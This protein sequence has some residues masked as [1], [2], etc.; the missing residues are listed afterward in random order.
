MERATPSPLS[1]V[2]YRAKV[3]ALQTK[4]LAFDFRFRPQRLAKAASIPTDVIAEARSTLWREQDPREWANEQGKV[5][6]LRVAAKA[7]DGLAIPAGKVFSFWKH[8]GRTTRGKGYVFGRQI[9]E[10]CL[11][12]A[13]G[14]GICQLTNLLYEVALNA[15]CEIVERHPHSR[16]VPG[17]PSNKPDATVAWNH[18]DLRFAPKQDLVLRVVL[19]SDELVVSL[20]GEKKSKRTLLP[21]LQ[22]R[23][24]KGANSCATCG[25]EDCF[26][27]Q[28]VEVSRGRRAVLVDAVWPEYVA[29]LRS[30]GL[31]D[32][33]L[34]APMDGRRFRRAA[35]EWPVNEAA[36]FYAATFDTL[37]RSYRSRR[38]ASEGPARRQA[39]LAADESLARSYARH[40]WPDVVR[41][42]V[43]Q[44]F[45]PF[46]YRDGV[47][48]GRSYE[49]LMTRLPIRELQRRLD[50]AASASP[51]RKSLSDFRAAGWMADAEW[52]ALEGAERIVTPHTEIA[53]LFPEK[54]MLL[55]WALPAAR[56]VQRGKAIAFPGPAIARKGSEVVRDLALNLGVPVVL[57]GSDLEAPG[58][59]SGVDLR[60]PQ[61][62]WLD[63][64]GCVVQPAVMED[65]PRKLLQALSCG[66]PVIATKECGIPARDGL[67]IAER[68]EFARAVKRILTAQPFHG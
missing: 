16:R 30:S 49:V 38:L 14:G 61:G 45:L 32:D 15:G 6:N 4:R 67:V 39:A 58:F 55:P 13:R 28:D 25:A 5:Q 53:V 51:S 1:N 11:I 60:R 3:L 57:A 26:R 19:T 23:A 62:F 34:M 37:M 24:L 2:L 47:L 56:P 48:G 64:V 36:S 21:L 68:D 31:D 20:L 54:T 8:I 12:P 43:Y 29:Y 22:E 18:I 41:L 9:Q 7:L 66:V 46:L 44:Q 63:G 42:T 17:A 65:Q 35:Y 40:L 10:G 33:L 27:H 59:W 52:A 50:I